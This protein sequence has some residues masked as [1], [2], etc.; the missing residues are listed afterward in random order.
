MTDVSGSRPSTRPECQ[1]EYGL[2][3]GQDVES[4]MPPTLSR[5]YTVLRGSETPEGT[6]IEH[7]CTRTWCIVPRLGE[8]ELASLAGVVVGMLCLRMSQSHETRHCHSLAAYSYPLTWAEAFWIS[9]NSLVHARRHTRRPSPSSRT[10][11]DVRRAAVTDFTW[12]PR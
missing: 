4:V 6:H 2:S 1:G 9:P 5:P 3:D 11:P 8:L 7:G 12:L 10:L